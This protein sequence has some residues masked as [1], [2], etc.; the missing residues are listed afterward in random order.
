V[1]YSL[2]ARILESQQLT[3][4][5]QRP[6]NNNRGMVFCAQSVPMAAHATVEYIMQSRSNS[7]T[8][9]EERCFLRCPCQ[10]II[11]RIK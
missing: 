8:A 9:T 7:C 5:R 11:S 6:V 2:R 3:V 4:T 10:Y 1:V